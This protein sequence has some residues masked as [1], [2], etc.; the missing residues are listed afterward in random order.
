[1]SIASEGRRT[2]RASCSQYKHLEPYDCHDRIGPY[3]KPCH[4]PFG[5]RKGGRCKD[6]AWFRSKEFQAA[7]ER[8]ALARQ[9]EEFQAALDRKELA[10]QVDKYFAKIEKLR[11]TVPWTRSD[12]G[13]F[14]MFDIYNPTV[15]IIGY[16]PVNV[17][18]PRTTLVKNWY[19]D[20]PT[21]TLGQMIDKTV[22]DVED[23]YFIENILP[24][25]CVVDE[26]LL[27]ELQDFYTLFKA[28][29]AAAR[30]DLKAAE[31]VACDSKW[32]RKEFERYERLMQHPSATAANRKRL[33]M[34]KRACMQ[35]SWA[36]R[37]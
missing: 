8:M 34:W 12:E 31:V 30:R 15:E 7:V 29:V 19:Q 21:E 11:R 5:K 24:D 27:R 35:T 2:P 18:M 37:G 36:R 14:G 9:A 28:T 3:A 10:K 23:E 20:H 17:G 25:Y 33:A 22:I 1:M 16:T 6:S 4:R 26:A 13:P 32:G